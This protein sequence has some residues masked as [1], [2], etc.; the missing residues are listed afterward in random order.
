MSYPI[1]L[2]IN[3]NREASALSVA[4]VGLIHDPTLEEGDSMDWAG[5]ASELAKRLERLRP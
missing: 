4:L 2:R 5:N 3:N 1:Y